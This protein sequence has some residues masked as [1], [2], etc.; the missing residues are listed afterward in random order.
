MTLTISLAAIKW[1]KSFAEITFE[2]SAQLLQ[3]FR[4]WQPASVMNKTA[5][6]PGLFVIWGPTI[7]PAVHTFL[8]S[9]I[10]HSEGNTFL[11]EGFR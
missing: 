10:E 3:R 8:F 2:L 4:R 7:S 11:V 6:L 1:T 9:G 5:G